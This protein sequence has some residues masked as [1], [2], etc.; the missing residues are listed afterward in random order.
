MIWNDKNNKSADTEEL[1]YQMSHIADELDWT[2]RATVPKYSKILNDCF[3]RYVAPINMQ[4][5]I[6][7]LLILLTNIIAE[8]V[9]ES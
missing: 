6:G 2:S 4:F 7:K 1:W 3:D 9:H 8:N 5:R